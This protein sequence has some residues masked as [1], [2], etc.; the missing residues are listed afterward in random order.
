GL[1]HPFLTIGVASQDLGAPF[2]TANA[3]ANDVNDSRTVVGW[4]LDSPNSQLGFIWSGG[5]FTQ[6]MPNPPSTIVQ[7]RVINN[8]GVIAGLYLA[9]NAAFHAYQRTSTGQFMDLHPATRG[10]V[11]S[12]ALGISETGIV[13][14][15]VTASNGEV[16]AAQW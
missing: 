10:Y 4:T 8:A 16:H 12:E 11:A 13:V 1:I 7:A 3:L 6:I 15:D 5:G 14:G 9:P 2:G